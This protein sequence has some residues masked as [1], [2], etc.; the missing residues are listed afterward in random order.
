MR[1]S[2]AA[3]T[4][5][6]CA[7]LLLEAP[8]A[9]QPLPQ[10]VA[11]DH[12]AASRNARTGG[13]FG[14][15]LRQFKADE[16]ALPEH[17]EAGFRGTT[18]VYQGERR[19][20]EGFWVWQRPYWFVFRDGPERTPQQRQ[21]GPEAACGAPDTP[22]PGDHGSAWAPKEP[23]DRGEWLLLEY[24]QPVRATALLV[25]ENF[26]PGAVAA[27]A[28]LTPQGE[29][30]E[31]WRN[32]DV[33][34]ATEPARVLTIDLP[35]GFDVERVL[36]SFES[37]NVPGSNEIDAVGLRD[38]KGNVH[39]ASRAEA[40][41]TFADVAPQVGRLGALRGL[42]FRNLQVQL[43]GNAL[44][45]L[46][47]HQGNAQ[48]LNNLFQVQR[49]AQN[50]RVQLAPIAGAD[51]KALEL[52]RVFRAADVQQLNGGLRGQV[53]FR[54]APDEKAQLQQRVAELEKRVKE[55]EAELARAKARK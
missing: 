48:V 54:A 50:L 32:K 31:L 19:I 10:K 15:L 46:N 44:Q 3:F 45:G 28:I 53:L 11:P 51:G 40:R 8:P 5:P 29:Q 34:A 22:Q 25:H 12:F 43:Q 7:S 21:W 33:K 49:N 42:N 18:Q 41:S 24:E 4:L 2:L 27:V 17:H 35:L 52:P 23:D 6:L 26:N 39:W 20:P 37:E 38:D 13:R 36:V 9:Q 47:V 55:L 16:P 1:S 14:M 30:L